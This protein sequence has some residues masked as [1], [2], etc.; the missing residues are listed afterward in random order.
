MSDLYKM[1]YLHMSHKRSTFP[2]R[3]FRT[4]HIV[5]GDFSKLIRLRALAEEWI[6]GYKNG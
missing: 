1:I 3:W 5:A 2:L 4:F 6:K